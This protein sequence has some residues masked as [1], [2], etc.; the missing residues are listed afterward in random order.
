MVQMYTHRG[1]T[2]ARTNHQHSDIR[3]RGR[4]LCN[5]VAQLREN[6]CP[7]MGGRFRCAED[8][9]VHPFCGWRVISCRLL[10]PDQK[11]NRNTKR[12]R[13]TTSPSKGRDSRRCGATRI[14]NADDQTRFPFLTEA[15][16]GYGLVVDP[17]CGRRPGPHVIA[18]G[19]RHRPQETSV[20]TSLATFRTATSAAW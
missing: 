1:L 19:V 8:Q 16:P 6:G 13:V 20:S 2:M 14:P 12:A 18:G 5:E 3:V 10:H 9:A 4:T 11:R 7:A 15:F 17:A